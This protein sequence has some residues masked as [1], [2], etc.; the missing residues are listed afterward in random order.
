MRTSSIALG[1]LIPFVSAL[2]QFSPV[3]ST[4]ERIEVL[5]TLETAGTKFLHAWPWEI[6]IWNL[7]LTPYTTIVPPALAPP[8]EARYITYVTESLFDDD[9]STI[10]YCQSYRDTSQVLQI[11]GFRVLREDGTILFDQLGGS[12]PDV[13]SSQDVFGSPAIFSTTEGTFM[14]VSL[15][16]GGTEVYELPGHVPCLDCSDIVMMTSGN[17]LAKVGATSLSAFPNPAGNAATVNYTLPQGVH[18]ATLVLSTLNGSVVSRMALTNSGSKTITT[19][20]LSAGTYLYHLETN[21]G[22][23]GAK[24]LVVVK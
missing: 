23:I 5:R 7:D 15:Q 4:D 21:Q 9:P 2:G 6:T 17:G 14:A 18:E 12:L 20:D 16:F 24:R 13:L 11:G 1:T 3:G 22:M 8:L 10:E 19:A